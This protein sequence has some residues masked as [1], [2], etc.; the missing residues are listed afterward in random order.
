MNIEANQAHFPSR[1]FFQ[2]PEVK[3]TLKITVVALS[4]LATIG[5]V[6]AA[7]ILLAAPLLTLI[8]IPVAVG[9]LGILFF[10]LVKSPTV[11]STQ[12]QAPE[13]E[14]YNPEPMNLPEIPKRSAEDEALF[15]AYDNGIA[16]IERL[17]RQCGV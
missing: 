2:K 13:P 11:H 6:L 10:D 4:A 16:A 15:K 17:R 9:A 12:P 1:A 5:A 3:Q 8:A 14:P 7:S